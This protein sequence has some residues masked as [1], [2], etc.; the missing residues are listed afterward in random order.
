MIEAFFGFVARLIAVCLA[1]VFVIGTAAVLQLRSADK[2]LLDPLTYQL[3]LAETNLYLRLPD[4]AVAEARHQRERMSEAGPDDLGRVVFRSLE[5]QDIRNLTQLLLPAAEVQR[6]AEDAL[7]QGAAYL[8]MRQDT[9]ALDLSRLKQ[10]ASGK[11]GTLAIEILAGALPECGEPGCPS[12]TQ[13][14]AMFAPKEFLAQYPDELVLMD[15]APEPDLRKD[16]ASARMAL[17][18]APLALGVLLAV[19]GLF[20]ARSRPGWL[21]WIGVP[22]LLAGLFAIGQGAAAGPGIDWVWTQYLGSL[23][24][25]L[26]TEVVAQVRAVFE[27]VMAEFVRHLQFEG[28]VVALVG[29]ALTL[30]SFFVPERRL[31]GA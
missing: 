14:A 9:L 17:G 20:G 29:F 11:N 2:V 28:G 25:E 16:L 27:A 15:G 31:H 30:A 5:E 1:L 6:L 19:I 18:F 4:L 3:A 7:D 22:L 26:S 23:D 12:S 8:E 24:Q 21:R 10:N 13:V